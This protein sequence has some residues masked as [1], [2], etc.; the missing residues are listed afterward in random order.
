MIEILIGKVLSPVAANDDSDLAFPTGTPYKGVVHS[1]NFI[2]GSSL[3]T[4]VGLTAG[5]LMNDLGGWLHIIDTNGL[6]LYIAKKPIRKNASWE[7]IMAATNNGTKEVTINGEVYFVTLLSGLVAGGGGVSPANAG[8]EWNK[9]MYPLYDTT[10]RQ[11]FPGGTPVWGSYTAAML[12]IATVA[13]STEPGSGTICSDS[14]G[15]GGYTSRGSNSGG[16]GSVNNMMGLWYMDANTP[17]NWYGWRPALRKK[18]TIPQTPFRGEVLAADFISGSALA[19][20]IGL[21]AGALIN[22][23]TPWLK[24]VDNGKTFYMPKKPIRMTF[25]WEN[26]NALGA[27]TGT[28]TVQIGGLTYKVRLMTGG[29]GANP[30]NTAGGEYDDYFSRVTTQYSGKNG[31]AWATY[32]PSDVGWDGGTANYE[33]ITCQEASTQGGYLLRGY[34]GFL[35]VWYQPADTAQSGYGWRPILELVP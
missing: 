12:G 24:F 33:L 23:T 29:N 5:T 4:A 18:S 6:E 9:Y 28:K 14:P 31:A 30:T 7:Q 25:S 11:Y 10:D 1:A 27:V 16:Y 13:A 22:D 3:A 21:S 2:S 34:P 26:L 35:G 20:A 15:G 32:A 19:A 17:Q 8:G